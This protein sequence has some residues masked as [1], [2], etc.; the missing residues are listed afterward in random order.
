VGSLALGLIGLILG[1]VGVW[2]GWQGEILNPIEASRSQVR[3]K[4]DPAETAKYILKALSYKTNSDLPTD[5]FPFQEGDEFRKMKDAHL[6]G[7]CLL[8][9]TFT[10]HTSSFI[11]KTYTGRVHEYVF[12]INL[13]D[14]ER[15]GA[16]SAM[17]MS[18]A[19]EEQ[20]ASCGGQPDR[21]AK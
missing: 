10:S 4:A 5:Y 3:A 6:E 21:F 7:N 16:Q 9:T 12:R 15:G 8:V 18:R 13:K 20:M 11:A 19:L 1:G 17:R 14:A 2:I